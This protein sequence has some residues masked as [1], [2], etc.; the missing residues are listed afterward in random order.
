MHTSWQREYDAY[1]FDL[2]GTLLDTAPDLDAALNFCLSTHGFASVSMELTR[3]WVGHGVR[4]LVQESILHNKM[5]PPVEN[6]LDVMVETF[7]GYYRS[8]LTE[9]T[10]PYPHVLETL[11]RLKDR[12]ARL[13]VVTNKLAELTEPILEQMDMAHFF[14]TVVSGDATAHSKPAPDPVLFCLERLSATPEQALFVGDSATDVAAALAAGTMVV[15]MRNGYNH[16][17]DV[18]SL[19]AHGI[20]DTFAEIL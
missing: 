4:A 10:I 16:G 9:T 20:I 17:V 6:Q 2:D 5:V 7:L 11:T 3:H 12:G 15:C 13:A 14:H 19:G 18:S 8:H 1:L